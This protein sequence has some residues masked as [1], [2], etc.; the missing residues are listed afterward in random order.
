MSFGG[1]LALATA[2]I[3]LFSCILMLYKYKY[4]GHYNLIGIH[5]IPVVTPLGISFIIF[6]VISYI[7][8]V[9][10]GCNAGK[11]IDV[12]NYICFFPK[13]IS[14][15]IVTWKNWG[16]LL[17][18]RNFEKLDARLSFF[19][20][21]FIIGLS[22]KVIIADSLGAMITIIG[23]G[24]MDVISAWLVTLMYSLRI[25]FD[26]SGYSDIA[27]GL[28]RFMGMEIAENFSF[29]YCS[30]SISEFWR[31]WHISLG[32]WFKEYVYIPLGGNRHGERRTCIN[33]FLVMFLSGIWHG[34]GFGYIVWG[35]IHGLCIVLE[36]LFADKIWYKKIPRIVKWGA[37]FFIVSLCW[38][39]FRTNSLSD[40]VIHFGKM[41][42]VGN[43][44]PTFM[45]NYYVTK[46]TVSLLIVSLFFA[47][48]FKYVKDYCKQLSICQTS[49]WLIIK[50]LVLLS[51][52]ALTLV[53]IT[54]STY[55]PF[56]YFQY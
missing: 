44:N 15:P 30:T 18:K 55:S 29:P 32:A 35:S 22:K 36:K 11:F 24:D 2:A 4:A 40:T 56:I 43:G 37:T 10:K 7:V 14:G 38:E 34:A 31:R 48:P 5:F 9:Y 41:I 19:L 20:E 54:N 3:A 12:I 45:F 49:G 16:M 23:N 21:R 6:S 33:L 26:F 53:F 13:V 52:F 27:I 50:N 28:A 1:F 25:Y 47:I 39:F 51:L 8:D 42:G 46:K 17:E